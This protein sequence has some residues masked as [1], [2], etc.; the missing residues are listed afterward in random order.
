MRAVNG[1]VPDVWNR[2]IK[3]LIHGLTSLTHGIDLYSCDNFNW[4]Q[5][6]DVPLDANYLTNTARKFRDIIQIWVKS[7]ELLRSPSVVLSRRKLATVLPGSVEKRSRKP[8]NRSANPAYSARI[9][10][11][12]CWKRSDKDIR[13]ASVILM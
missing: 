10:G 6:L 1:R 2:L 5:H 7:S 11:S 8:A 13:I 4:N 12:A 3:A 9:E